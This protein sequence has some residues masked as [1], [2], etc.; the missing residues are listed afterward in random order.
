MRVA[1]NLSFL[2]KDIPFL[3]RFQAAASCGKEKLIYLAVYIFY[4]YFF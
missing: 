1:A 2:F 3:E 4:K